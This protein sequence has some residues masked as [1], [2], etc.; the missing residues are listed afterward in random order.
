MDFEKTL[1]WWTLLHEHFYPPS[2][3]LFSQSF[4]YAQ[5]IFSTTIRKATGLIIHLLNILRYLR[6][7]S[8]CVL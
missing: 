3:I 8:F 1:L 7:D 2:S 6:S 4:N 5:N